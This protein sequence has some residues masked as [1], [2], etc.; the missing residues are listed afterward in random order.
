[1]TIQQKLVTRTHV[2]VA[3]Q[4]HCVAGTPAG[5][6]GSFPANYNSYK[7]TQSQQHLHMLPQNFHQKNRESPLQLLFFHVYVLDKFSIP[8]DSIQSDLFYS[9]SL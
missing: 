1:M 9:R 3:S 8:G 4:A 6:V 2:G 5:N 7:M